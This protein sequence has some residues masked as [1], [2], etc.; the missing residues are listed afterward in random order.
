MKWNFCCHI[1]IF[2]LAWNTELNSIYNHLQ[3]LKVPHFLISKVLI[4]VLAKKQNWPNATFW[5]DQTLTKIW[6]NT[7]LT[8]IANILMV[9]KKQL[10]M[11]T[12]LPV[13]HNFLAYKALVPQFS[14]GTHT[15]LD[16]PY[17]DHSF[18][19]QISLDTWLGIPLLNH[20]CRL[21]GIHFQMGEASIDTNPTKTVFKPIN[22]GL[23][24]Q[25]PVKIVIAF[26]MVVEWL[27]HFTNIIKMIFIL[28]PRQIGV[29]AEKV[30][31]CTHPPAKRTPIHAGQKYFRASNIR[32]QPM[33]TKIQTFS[34][35]DFLL[36]PSL[37]L[38]GVLQ[39]PS[40]NWKAKLQQ[41][42]Q[43]LLAIKFRIILLKQK[44]EHA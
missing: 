28:L 24:T 35:P 34:T 5:L 22:Y 36:I 14:H 18:V 11:V 37:Y 13:F 16:Q 10:S 3:S 27:N 41:R 30:H 31:L 23:Q 9:T 39:H 20:H 32:M 38:I 7:S 8:L 40:K 25:Q 21:C 33:N 6:L 29:S 42:V 12:I 2:L 1:I 43:P 44:I 17:L 4:Y 26:V 19:W 15:P